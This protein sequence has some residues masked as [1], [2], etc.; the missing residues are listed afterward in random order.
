MSSNQRNYRGRSPSPNRRQGGSDHRHGDRKSS[1]DRRQGG[2]D[3]RHGDRKSSPDRR[4]VGSDHRQGGRQSSPDRRQGGSDH[5]HVGSDRRQGG[6]QSSPDRHQGGSDH[7]HV[8]SD[9]RQCG[10][11]SSPTRCQEEQNISR[12][13]HSGQTPCRRAANGKKC[14]PGTCSFYP[15]NQDIST[16]NVEREFEEKRTIQPR[17]K[18]QGSNK[19]LYVV[20]NKPAT[21]STTTTTIPTTTPSTETVKPRRPAPPPPVMN[22]EAFAFKKFVDEYL[23]LLNKGEYKKLFEIEVVKNYMKTKQENYDCHFFHFVE[24]V[25]GEINKPFEWF[26]DIKQRNLFNFERMRNHILAK[27]LEQEDFDDIY[28]MAHYGLWH[29]FKATRENEFNLYSFNGLIMCEFAANYAINRMAFKIPTPIY[30]Y[31][32]NQDFVGC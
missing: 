17:G 27:N 30:Q 11:Q 26:N 8:G 7:R 1:P 32:S 20:E 18:P 5:R 13:N 31:W 25:Y 15:C 3:H 12:R 16:I 22:T 29:L 2:S 24:M 23:P 6:R 14:K 19:P 21:T 4:H 9:H 10:R 28:N